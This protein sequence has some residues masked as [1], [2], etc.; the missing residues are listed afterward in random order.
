MHGDEILVPAIVFGTIGWVIKTIATN[1]RQSHGARAVADL[2]SKLLDKCAGSQDLIAYLESDAG[3]KF[4]ESATLERANPAGRIL[5]ALQAGFVLGLVGIAELTVRGL[6]PDINA[7]RF[8][9][10]TGAVVLAIGVGF[11]LSAG[12]SYVLCRSWGLLNPADARR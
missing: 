4:L 6:E 10:V 11:L 1:I 5:N 9:L 3:R 8:L 7:E 12:T 2:H